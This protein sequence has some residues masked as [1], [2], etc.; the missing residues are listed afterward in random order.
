MS[1]IQCTLTNVQQ[2]LR[3]NK[4]T[5]RASHAFLVS[6]QKAF[7]NYLHVVGIILELPKAY[8]VINHNILL[9]KLDSYGVR[10]STNMWFKSYLTNRTQFV[11]IS[12]T[13]RNNCTR[14]FRLH[15]RLH[16][17]NFA[18]FIN[19]IG[20]VIEESHNK[21]NFRRVPSKEGGYIECQKK[22]CSGW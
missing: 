5:D 7:D 3:E 15:Y 18:L 9:D 4:C 8:D 22:R 11:E 20:A 2:G 1:I 13:N 21:G 14:N 19:N 6:A 12:R 10:G 17:C 16:K